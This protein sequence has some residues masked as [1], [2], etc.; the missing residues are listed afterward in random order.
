MATLATRNLT[1][2]DVA[3][4]LDA[5]GK[6]DMVIELINESNEVTPD[7]VVK[8]CNNGTTH[9][10]TVRTGIPGGTWRVLYGGIQSEK[11]STKQV[12][13]SCGMLEALPKIDVDV[14][15]KAGDP[16]GTLLSEHTAFLE[17][18]AQEV[19]STIW[20]GDTDTNPE[21]FMGMH[22]RYSVLS[23]DKT[24]SGYNVFDAGGT[25]ADNTSIWILSHGDNSLH[26]IYPKG[27]KAG[28]NIDNL[29]K[30]LTIAE[31]ASGDFLAYVTHYKWDIGLTLRDWRSCG[32]ICNIDMS[33][34]EAGTG[35][36]IINLMI[37]VSERLRGSG[38]KVWY[39]HERVRTM[40]RIQMRED[41][42]TNLTFETVE[43]KKVMMFDGIPI[44]ISD[45]LLL[46]EARIV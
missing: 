41:T 14:V 4:R 46:T 33:N 11:S 15:D 7:L 36:E 25:D 20:Y 32:R 45:K 8:E 2:A 12:V 31:D 38:R 27:S 3:K 39:M 37:K 29:G 26:A 43:G 30:Q 9:K 34:L 13:D 19:E 10:T 28:M 18:L 16:E 6:V 44:H 40:L 21:R 24:K 5:N 1:L 23:T 35:A 17:G 22:P 42:N